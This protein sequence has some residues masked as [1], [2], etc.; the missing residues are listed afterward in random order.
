MAIKK[1]FGGQS[2]RKP[3]AYSKSQVSS[4]AG[5]PLESNDTLLLVGEADAGQGGATDGIQFFSASAL[6]RLIAKYRTGPIVDA[7]KNVLQPSRTPGVGGAGRIGVYQTNASSQA[8]LDLDT[9]YG[10]LSA[11][12][13]GVGGNRI[14]EKVELSAETLAYVEGSAAVTNFAGLDTLTLE[15]RKNGATSESVTFSSPANIGDVVSQINAQTTGL[16]ATETSGVLKIEADARTN[17]HRD[18]WGQSVEVVDGTGLALLFLTAGQ[19]GTAES[20]YEASISTAQPRDSISESETVG[21]EIAIQIGRDD[22]DSCTAAT[23][24]ITATTVVLTATGSDSYTLTK[25][26]VPL[27]KNLRDAVAALAGWSCSI[28]SILS[29]VATAD[30][31][32][33]SAIGAFSEA[34]NKP[35]RIKRDAA[36]VRDVYADSSLVELDQ[37]AVKGL[38]DAL[39]LTNLSGGAKG[40]SASSAF[41]AG[42]SAALGE[43]VNVIVPLIS[44]DASEDILDGETD[45]A[46]TYDIET[47]HA[48]LDAHLRLRG[49]IK[50]RKE[51]QGMVGYRK[52][53]RED[54]FAQAATLGSELIQ[55][56]MED[57]LVID[58]S[59][60]LTWKKPHVLA[61]MLAGMRLGVPEIGEPLTHK[62][63]AVQGAG[64]YVNSSTGVIEGDYNP[65]VDFDEALDAG[66]TS[67]EPE[68]GSFRVMC[69]NTTYGVDA[70]FVFNRGSVIEAA[71]Y[72][73][74]TVRKDAEL[75]FVGKKNAVI[76]A[77]AI[78]SRIRTKLRELFGAR[79]TSPSEDAPEGFREDTFIVQVTGNTAE[80]QVEVK[81]VQGLDFIFITFTL[82]ET[83][84]SA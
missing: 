61:A 2:I 37:D 33:V 18:G 79:I 1:S 70:N 75:T 77:S 43:E 62:F 82:G 35:A 68:S 13:Y 44:Q 73:A 51:A 69:D 4:D 26:E 59:N 45:A 74:K 11:I 46:S 71:Q 7:A 54:V 81:P 3:G 23:V 83:R 39:S 52:Q 19:F 57:V 53:A 12:E 27:L 17:G 58:S 67:L 60:E 49:N 72:I 84:Q 15:V 16:T 31:D 64:H 63:L 50:N 56:C 38:P 22:S 41:D 5:S 32:Q 66:V 8:S 80:V 28:P 42:F 30:L 47:V 76:T 10:T 21:D 29:N 24:Q 20:E 6:N 9:T 25:A 78:K 34:A 48:A 40:S 55:L 65:L 14:T 36:Q